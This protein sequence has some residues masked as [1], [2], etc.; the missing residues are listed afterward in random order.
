[1]ANENQNSQDTNAIENLNSQLT[2]ASLRLANNKKVIYWIAGGIAVVAVFILSYLFIYRN[3]RINKSWEAYDKVQLDIAKQSM[4]DSVAAGEFAKVADN[5]SGTPAGEVAALSAAEAFYNIGKWDAAIK[6]LED[7]SCSEPVMEAQAKVLLADC[8]VN[9][10]AANYGKALDLY[11]KAVKIADGNPQIVPAVLLK[12]AN[13]YD[14]QKNYSEALSCYKQIQA[15]Y[16]EFMPGNG[17]MIESYIER[18]IAR[19]AK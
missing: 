12:E 3:P 19:G 17:M 14:A 15:E 13:V 5:Y 9:K 7:F 6:Y 4:T 10:G 1:M 2:G 18:E 8:Y 11:K 16:P